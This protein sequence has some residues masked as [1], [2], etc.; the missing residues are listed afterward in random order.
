MTKLDNE[1]VTAVIPA[2]N[3]RT[4]IDET[5]SS[6]RGQTHQA[7]EILVVDDGSVDDTPMIVERHAR[8]D[9]RVR[10]IRQPNAGVAAAR[11][12]GITEA[13]A[14]WVAPV[15]ADD[16]WHPQKI[17]LQLQAL[18]EGGDAVGVVY[19]W[20][21]IIDVNSR[22]IAVH[23]PSEE[24]NVFERMCRGNLVGNG[25]STLMRKA[26]V[27]EVG[28]Y[29]SDLRNSGAQGC[30]DHL[31][32]L[33]MAAKYGYRVVKSYLTGYRYLPESMS[34]DVMQMLRS[35]DLMAEKFCRE[36]PR[37]EQGLL[38]GRRDFINYYYRRALENGWW[39]DALRLA[40]EMMKSA[41]GTTV[42][43]RAHLS[44]RLLQQALTLPVKQVVK[45]V[46]RPPLKRPRFP[47]K[48]PA[49]VHSQD[50]AEIATMVDWR[51]SRSAQ[52]SSGA[53]AT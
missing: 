49:R 27:L 39:R 35:Y 22:V 50:R 21:A 41:A 3:A 1:L 48:E 42:S 14:A 29:D 8:E 16:I 44:T 9:R 18:R 53:A 17:E 19:T 36:H 30:E 52:G 5:L 46:L 34:H 23:K 45:P 37:S 7:L 33:H 13:Q 32:Y 43:V 26:A 11:N 10:L 31:L 25:S 12:R 20:Y 4:T 6:V 51:S 2:Y 15:D 47:L 40:G 28:G 38:E 24:G